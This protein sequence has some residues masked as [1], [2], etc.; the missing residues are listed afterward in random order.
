[1]MFEK[2]KIETKD[3]IIEF[4]FRS[5]ALFR[6]TFFIITKKKFILYLLHYILRYIFNK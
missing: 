6:S 4:G 2:L 1:M 3:I 5:V